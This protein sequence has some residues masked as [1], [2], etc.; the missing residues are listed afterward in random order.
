MMTLSQP[1][2]CTPQP[3]PSE[4]HFTAQLGPP[5]VDGSFAG[6]RGS[7]ARTA[8]LTLRDRDVGGARKFVARRQGT[9]AKVAVR[10]QVQRPASLEKNCPSGGKLSL[11][12]VTAAA[13]ED[14][15]LNVPGTSESTRRAVGRKM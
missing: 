8:L 1:L 15:D 13:D 5:K 10:V 7:G 14:N 9:V 6:H 12:M 11:A 3:V 4:K 2:S